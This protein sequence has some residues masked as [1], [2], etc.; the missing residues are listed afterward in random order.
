MYEPI[1]SLGQNFL[2]KP[3]IVASMVDALGIVSG[4]DIIEIG[5]GHGILTEILLHRVSDRDV[6]VYC[7]RVSRR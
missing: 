7:T 3:S 1:K 4:E 5:P 6:K 2:S